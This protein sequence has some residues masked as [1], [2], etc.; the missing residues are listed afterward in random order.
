MIKPAVNPQEL[1]QKYYRFDKSASNRVATAEDVTAET[2]HVYRDLGYVVIDQVLSPEEV[3]RALTEISDVIHGRIVGPKIQYGPG[4]REASIDPEMA[5]R[6]LHKFIDHCPAL[7]H[8]C[9]HPRILA[10]LERIFGEAPRF[11]EDQALLK[12]PSKEA[13]IE[14]PWHQDMAYSNFSFTRMVVGVWVALDEATIDNGCMHVIPG[15]HKNGPTPHYAVRD[16]QI[17]DTSVDVHKDET[18]E[19]KPG[20]VLV[21]CGLLHH[22]TPP[23]MSMKSRRALQFH[24]APQ[25]A[26]KM[27]P[28][29]YKVVFTNEMTQAEC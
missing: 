1:A 27:T 12:P 18:V 5:V 13:G 29:E 8:I 24:Y 15:S 10:L 28:Q 23:N 3:T 17:C 9:Y 2:I 22:G 14:K 25:T 19:L 7:H 26:V 21:F 20:G 6:K 4:A 16:W 11:C